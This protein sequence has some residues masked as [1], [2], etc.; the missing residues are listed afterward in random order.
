M[1]EAMSLRAIVE[2]PYGRFDQDTVNTASQAL[3]NLSIRQDLNR[4]SPTVINQAADLNRQLATARNTLRRVVVALDRLDR[5]YKLLMANIPVN[6][7]ILS[8]DI[9]KID[10]ITKKEIDPTFSIGEDGAN[11]LPPSSNVR[12]YIDNALK[13]LMPVRASIKQEGY[14]KAAGVAGLEAKITN[15]GFKPEPNYGAPGNPTNSVVTAPVLAYKPAIASV[16]AT[17]AKK[18][19]PAIIVKNTNK[20]PLAP[21]KKGPTLASQRRKLA[22]L[23]AG[24]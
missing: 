5:I 15:L 24:R 3:Y 21:I 20:K 6:L 17:P 23:K 11:F 10:P 2:N 4:S 22:R 18:S 1:D 9:Y 13:Q 8:Y 12:L 19:I 7:D 16:P 14:N